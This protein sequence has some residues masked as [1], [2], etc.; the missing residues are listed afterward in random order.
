MAGKPQKL[1][2][3]MAVSIINERTNYVIDR[4]L[5]ENEDIGKLP[6]WPGKDF[7][8]AVDSPTDSERKNLDLLK[9]EAALAL[10]G[11]SMAALAGLI[12]C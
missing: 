10:L 6:K 7:V 5:G 12:S 4:I 11:M 1:N 9:S 3:I 8:F 2:Y